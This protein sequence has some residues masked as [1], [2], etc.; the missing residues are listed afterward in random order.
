MAMVEVQCT[1]C[2][3]RYRINQRLLPDEAP[4]FKCSR[5]GHVFVFEPRPPEAHHSKMAEAAPTDISEPD[6]EPPQGIPASPVAMPAV[7]AALT[8]EAAPQPVTAEEASARDPLAR[9]F[10]QHAD[11]TE[12]GEHLTFDF[13]QET[14]AE[15]Q[16]EPLS[17]D[18][19]GGDD[20]E[21]GG[22]AG[23]FAHT[24]EPPAESTWPDRGADWSSYRAPAREKKKAAVAATT[25]DR[26]TFVKASLM[27]E[28]PAKVHSASL[29]LGIF[30]LVV[31]GFGAVS[32]IVVGAPAA[33]ADFFNGLPA[34]GSRFARPARAASLVTLADV[35]A[36]YAHLKDGRSAL[37]IGGTARNVGANPLHVVEIAA[38]LRDD[39][40]HPLAHTQGYCGTNLSPAMV[41]QMTPREIEFLE[42]I[43]PAR[44]FSLA[45][46]GRCSFA[47]V[48]LNPAQ[49]ARHFSL[50]VAGAA[51]ETAAA[52]GN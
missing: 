5:C 3:T 36:S 11:E 47:L 52:E 25:F 23:E 33:S 24:E 46:E 30:L 20:W 42:R 21:I 28:Q 45:P 40:S 2:H 9:D 8:G 49:A 48:F 41:S 37:V 27:R 32:M 22:E 26:A 35:Q 39:G 29:F 16:A 13:E 7:R 15:T 18:V 4:T 34:I 10:E 44:G 1:S 12:S 19:G 31:L 6:V 51:V 17:G 50:L 38:D 43:G 14:A